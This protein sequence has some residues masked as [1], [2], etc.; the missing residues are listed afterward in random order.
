MFFK[1]IIGHEFQKKA[2][3]RTVRESRISHAYLFFG[4]DGIGKRLISV[5]FAK[6]LNC[7]RG[8]SI[9][10][11]VSKGE[12][13]DCH[14][15]KK[16]EK[17]IHPDVFFVE[18]KGIK[19]IRVDQIRE[20]VEERLFLTPFEGRFKVAIVDEAERMNPNAQNAFLKTLEEP[21]P[22]SVIILIS[23]RPEALLPTIR[24]RCQLLEFR[25][26]SEEI[27]LKE[28]RKRTDLSPDEA[29]VAVKLSGGSLG[30]ALGL[31]KNVLSERKEIILKLSEINPKYASQVLGFVESMPTGS[32]SEDLEK[33]MFVFE[34]ISAWLRDLVLIKIGFDEDHLSNRDLVS[35]IRK[36][37]EKWSVDN[38]LD[39]MKFLE[40]AW[41]AVFRMNA[42]K[43][44]VLE[45]LVLKIAE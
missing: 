38:I 17:G 20:E 8:E 22:D 12:R 35:P 40:N 31:D 2:L 45:N 44:I 19:N 42:N 34:I 41:Y 39:K 1:N 13:C 26:L 9:T 7:L 14:S 5:E 18:Y 10:E 28:F 24:S 15:C 16:I 21:P 37:A 32:S 30:K 33:L 43:Q 23:S 4:P 29:W 3:I 25:G 36:L 11:E 27:M 6:I